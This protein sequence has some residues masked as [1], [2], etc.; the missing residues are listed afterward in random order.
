MTNLERKSM[1]AFRYLEG[2]FKGSGMDFVLVVA[3]DKNT[4]LHASNRQMGMNI[5]AAINE[6]HQRSEQKKRAEKN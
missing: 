4:D 1:E 6:I 3:D 2:K 5:E